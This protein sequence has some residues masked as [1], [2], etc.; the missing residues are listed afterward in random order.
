MR[1]DSSKNSNIR[2]PKGESI[3]IITEESIPVIFCLFLC[4]FIMLYVLRQS[5]DFRKEMDNKSQKQDEESF[6]E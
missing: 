1:F 3:E 6:A 5:D 4:L 2:N